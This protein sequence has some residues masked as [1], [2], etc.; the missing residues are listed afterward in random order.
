MSEVI[1]HQGSGADKGALTAGEQI[2]SLLIAGDAGDGDAGAEDAAGSSGAEVAAR[3]AHLGE[4]MQRHVQ[5]LAH[6]GR[7]DVSLD[8]EE[9]RAGRIRGVGGVHRS[10]GEFP[11]EP[12]VDRAGSHT[13]VMPDAA[14]G[15]EPFQLGAGEVRVE[16]E[17]R[18]R[19]DRRQVAGAR[20]VIASVGGPTVLPDDGAMQRFAGG[21]IPDHHGLPLVGDADGDHV[22][23][24]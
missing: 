2:R 1:S 10:I 12:G 16:D 3:R 21:P 22:L 17:P 13:G 8:V 5:Q 6:L 18:D 19:A 9:H 11:Q 23:A 14:L 20:E 15:E 7:P 4:H 24:L